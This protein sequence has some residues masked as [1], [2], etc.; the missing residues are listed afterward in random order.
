MVDVGGEEHPQPGRQL[1]HQGMAQLEGRGVVEH[2]G[3]TLDGLDDG[4]ARVAGVDAPQAGRAVQ[5]RATVGGEVVHVLGRGQQARLGLEAA[6]RGERHPEGIKVVGGPCGHACI[7]SRRPVVLERSR[8][9]RL[10][11][12]RPNLLILR[13]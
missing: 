8:K 3:L 13:Q 4:F 5:D 11:L 1:E 7:L 9:E 10:L 6:V 2:L 12:V